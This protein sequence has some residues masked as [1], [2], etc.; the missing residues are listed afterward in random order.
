MRHAV[1]LV[2]LSLAASVLWGCSEDPARIASAPQ[3]P[4]EN[5]PLWAGPPPTEEGFEMLVDFD[6]DPWG[7]PIPEDT[8]LL[9][10]YM[11][12]GLRFR[13]E[14]SPYDVA[15]GGSPGEV[16]SDEDEVL[17]PPNSF[18]AELED[19][20]EEDE[21]GSPRGVYV[22][23]ETPV[24]GVGSYVLADEDEGQLVYLEA[25]DESLQSLGVV[26]V[27]ASHEEWRLLEFWSEAPIAAVRFYSLK[28]EEEEHHGEHEGDEDH[29]GDSEGEDCNSEDEEEHH[30]EW[31]YEEF[32]MDNLG[33]TP[34]PAGDEEGPGGGGGGGAAE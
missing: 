7:L 25:F 24:E 17:S 15:S 6:T 19:E 13:D 28:L 23:F 9:D 20:E 8:H 27:E 29:S 30:E 33:F 1:L 32:Y 4:V 5:R 22:L 2:S 18:E 34:V 21:E 14:L 31:E 16:E 11:P 3:T 26:S 10:E 12:M